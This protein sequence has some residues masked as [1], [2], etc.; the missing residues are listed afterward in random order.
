MYG[1]TLAYSP[2]RV[3]PLLV[4]SQS[5]TVPAADAPRSSDVALTTYRSPLTLEL[6]C[7]RTHQGC[8]QIDR[9]FVTNAAL[10]TDV[11]TVGL[12]GPKP[13][14]VEKRKVFRPFDSE[15]GYERLVWEI[16]PRIYTPESLLQ[17]PLEVRNRDRSH[18]TSQ[19]LPLRK[20][21]IVCSRVGVITHPLQSVVQ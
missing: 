2:E 12:V 6:W 4:R 16:R 5:G 11:G 15:C 8:P 13:A 7:R 1:T 19:Q 20:Y 10:L 21:G 18:T 9:E 3:A 14:W 17:M